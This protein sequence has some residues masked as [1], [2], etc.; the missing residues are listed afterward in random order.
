MGKQPDPLVTFPFSFNGN[1]IITTSGGGMLLSENREWIEH[2]RY[3]STQAREP[4]RHYEHRTIGYNYRMSNVL[5]ALGTSQISGLGHRIERR[6][7]HFLAYAKAFADLESFSMMPV[8]PSGEPNYW[9]SCLLVGDL[10]DTLIEALEAES[11]EARPI[12]NPC[13][14][15][16]PLLPARCTVAHRPSNSLT[17]NLPPEWF[18]FDPR[19]STTCDRYCAVTDYLT[20]HLDELNAMNRFRLSRILHPRNLSVA[21]FYILVLVASYYIGYELRFDFSVP[22]NHAADRVSTIWWVIVMKLMLLISFGQV[23][24]VLSYFRLPDALRLFFSLFLGCIV[25]LSMWY[26]YAGD[27]V[28]PRAVILSDFL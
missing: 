22:E 13:I 9:L 1:K 15:S 7:A 11:I 6:K 14:C 19:G 8:D 24:C 28:P 26:V 23:H 4:V 16:R 3:L 27:Q 2:A 5:A 21:L 25:L 10:R 17:W 18:R 12:W 20:K